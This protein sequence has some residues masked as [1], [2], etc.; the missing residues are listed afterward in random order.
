M[1]ITEEDICQII[2]NYYLNTSEEEILFLFEDI[3]QNCSLALSI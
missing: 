1:K 2:R 3:T